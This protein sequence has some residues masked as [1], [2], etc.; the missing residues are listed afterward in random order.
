MKANLVK[1]QQLRIQSK[2]KK[3]VKKQLIHQDKVS[4]TTSWL[5]IP[6]SPSYTNSPSG[7]VWLDVKD[8]YLGYGF[9]YTESKIGYFINVF[10]VKN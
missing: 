1:R 10:V 7:V 6:I 3:I 5:P 8:S 9:M 2:K 4:V